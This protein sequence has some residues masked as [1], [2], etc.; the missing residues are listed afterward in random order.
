MGGLQSNRKPSYDANGEGTGKKIVIFF[1]GSQVTIVELF[2][3]SFQSILII[4]R[5]SV[6]L[7]KERLERY[8]R[9]TRFAVKKFDLFQQVA[10]DLNRFLFFRSASFRR[11]TPKPC[12]Q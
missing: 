10:F 11:R 7:E 1:C 6:L 3:F 9:K 5:Y 2:I 12:M 8:V 4:S